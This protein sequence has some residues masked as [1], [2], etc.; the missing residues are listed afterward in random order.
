LPNLCGETKCII[1]GPLFIDAFKGDVRREYNRLEK[2][3]NGLLIGSGPSYEK[4]QVIAIYK[5]LIL[6]GLESSDRR[7]YFKPH[8]RS[9]LLAWK[10][11]VRELGA[12]SIAKI[13]YSMDELEDLSICFAVAGFT[14][15]VIDIANRG[16]PIIWLADNKEADYFSM[17]SYFLPRVTCSGKLPK[18]ISQILVRKDY[19][20]QRG[21]EFA[22]YHL[23]EEKEPVKTMASCIKQLVA[24]ELPQNFHSVCGGKSIPILR[25]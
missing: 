21:L 19:F 13:V 20:G 15:A 17:E 12:E 24:G 8:P 9:D 23:G 25:A 14:N 7:V 22:N 6:W 1:T 5:A 11:L 4:G 16:I 18:I 3:G 2:A 10:S